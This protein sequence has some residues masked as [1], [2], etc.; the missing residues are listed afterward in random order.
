MK[1]ELIGKKIK[2]I[3]SKNPQLIGVEG[4]I[5]DESKNMLSIEKDGKVIQIVKDQCVFDVEGQTVEG[6]KIAKRPE[7]RIK[8]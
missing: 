4:T 6:E 7:E 3:D 8:K 2:I 1:E 5:I